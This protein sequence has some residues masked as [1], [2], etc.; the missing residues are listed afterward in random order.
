MGGGEL[1]GWTWGMRHGAQTILYIYMAASD[2]Q[3][4]HLLG[5]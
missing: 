2:A 5:A 4:S 3:L 1:M